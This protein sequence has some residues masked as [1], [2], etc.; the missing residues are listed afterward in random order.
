MTIPSVD[1]IAAA[2]RRAKREQRLGN[3]P[4]CV[5][6]GFTNIDAL[7]PLGRNILEAHHIVGRANDDELT[8]PVCS[9]CH[10]VLTAGY[11]D[12][13]VSLH[14]PPTL[15]HKLVAILRALG[16]MLL[17]IGNTCVE[18]ADQLIALIARLD[19]KLPTW[20]VIE[21]QPT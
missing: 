14:R 12:A 3:D 1:P 16:V 7:I 6:C 10:R 4:A 17:A 11:L 15:L 13:G 8:V 9:N 19:E 2:A 20:R 21:E 18:W 5:L